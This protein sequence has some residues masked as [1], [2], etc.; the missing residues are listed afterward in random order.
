[1]RSRMAHTA[2]EMNGPVLTVTDSAGNYAI[3]PVDFNLICL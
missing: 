1:M 3:L 2:I